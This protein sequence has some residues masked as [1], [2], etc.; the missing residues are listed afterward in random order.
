MSIATYR[1]YL[2]RW[3]TGVLFCS[4]DSCTELRTDENRVAEVSWEAFTREVIHESGAP[5]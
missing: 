2:I 3:D 5:A 4:L 1:H